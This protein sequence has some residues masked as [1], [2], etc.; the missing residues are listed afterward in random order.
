MTCNVELCPNYFS[1]NV[2]V[3]A[4]VF[5]RQFSKNRQFCL[6]LSFLEKCRQN[7]TASTKTFTENSLQRNFALIS[8]PI[9]PLH[10]PKFCLIQK[11]QK[12]LRNCRYLVKATLAVNLIFYK[13]IFFETLIIFLDL[14]SN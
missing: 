14:Q 4:V 11:Q 13:L 8:L 6:K 1:V 3:L 9:Y 5:R 10:F 12:T 2:S 7:T